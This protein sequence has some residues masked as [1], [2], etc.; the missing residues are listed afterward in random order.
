MSV[1]LVLLRIGSNAVHVYALFFR[2]IK[3]ILVE[4]ESVGENISQ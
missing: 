4:D 1:T 3:V 2:S